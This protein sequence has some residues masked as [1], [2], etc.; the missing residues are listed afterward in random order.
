VALSA[1]LSAL[2]FLVY[3]W[4]TFRH[5]AGGYGQIFYLDSSAKNFTSLFRRPF[6]PG[7]AGLLVSPGKGLLVFAP[8]FLFLS[9]AVRSRFTEKKARMLALCVAAAATF[10]LFLYARY[11]WIGGYSYGPRLMTD[12]MP[13]LILLLVPVVDKLSVFGRAAF[14]TLVGASFLVQAIGAFC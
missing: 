11:N 14:V 5:W 9:L 13:F 3:N 2:P 7:L 8:F 4:V 12:A 10:H 6:L 1:V